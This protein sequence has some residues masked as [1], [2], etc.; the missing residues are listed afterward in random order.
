MI[1]RKIGWKHDAG[2]IHMQ[3]QRDIRRNFQ[4]L[5]TRMDKHCLFY[6]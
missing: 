2:K 6:E 5:I 4:Y 1:Q 3:K